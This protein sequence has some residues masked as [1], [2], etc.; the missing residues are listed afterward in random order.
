MSEIAINRNCK[1]DPIVLYVMGLESGVH[2]HPR[3]GKDL[4][5]GELQLVRDR[6][7]VSQ[8]NPDRHSGLAAP[9]SSQLRTTPTALI[10]I[11]PAETRRDPRFELLRLEDYDLRRASLGIRHGRTRFPERTG[12]DL[13]GKYSPFGPADLAT[14]NLKS[15]KRKPPDSRNITTSHSSSPNF[16]HHFLLQQRPGVVIRS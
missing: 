1:G 16:Y 2:Y 7:N 5:H 12:K 9:L 13:P 14:P 6:L 4:R 3:G 8:I 10:R 11:Q 15:Y